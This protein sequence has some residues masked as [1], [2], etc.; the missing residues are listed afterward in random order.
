MKAPWGELWDE[1]P[2][3]E[4]AVNKC[5]DEGRNPRGMKTPR[6]ERPVKTPGDERPL[7]GNP[8]G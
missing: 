5:S 7:G 1:C 4:Y 3:D 8:R 6:D 2:W